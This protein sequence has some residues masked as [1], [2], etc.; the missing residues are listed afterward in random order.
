MLAPQLPQLKRIGLR[1]ISKTVVPSK[2]LHMIDHPAHGV[3]YP[4][5]NMNMEEAS[6]FRK[7]LSLIGFSALNVLTGYSLFLEPLL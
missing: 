3:V 1:Y 5:L 2:K 4:V 7:K 6:P